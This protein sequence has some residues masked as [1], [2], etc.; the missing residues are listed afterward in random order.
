[1][2]EH[3]HLF[4]RYIQDETETA[5]IFKG[6]TEKRVFSFPSFPTSSMMP[7]AKRA[8]TDDPLD[9]EIKVFEAVETAAQEVAAKRTN[10]K[11]L[12]FHSVHYGISG[13]V[14]WES[15]VDVLLLC[16]DE[17]QGWLLSPLTMSVSESFYSK[18]LKVI[19]H[20]VM[21]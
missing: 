19:S 16:F 18:T 12:V 13:D 11:F 4:N 3:V 21:F 2:A 9:A 7:A 15:D 10:M 8:K 5:D 6:N 17:E 1:M 20:L 14:K